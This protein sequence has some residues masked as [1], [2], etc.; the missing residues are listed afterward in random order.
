MYN[1]KYTIM[2]LQLF[3]TVHLHLK[4]VRIQPAKKNK[5]QLRNV[6]SNKVIKDH[7]HVIYHVEAFTEQIQDFYVLFSGRGADIQIQS[8]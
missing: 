4:Y 8:E 3:I 1:V 6:D 7:R 5:A 2:H